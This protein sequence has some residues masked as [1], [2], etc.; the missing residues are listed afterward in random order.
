[1]FRMKLKSLLKPYESV[2]ADK[3]YRGDLQCYTPYDAK[4]EEAEEM[5]GNVLARHETVNRCLKLFGCLKTPFR[6]DLR[7][8]G[9]CFNAAVAVVQLETENGEPPYQ[10]KEFYDPIE[11]DD[12]SL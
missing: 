4:T 1:M 12:D 11:V 7:K 6:N 8:H 9:L 10:C 2:M 5:M 3:G